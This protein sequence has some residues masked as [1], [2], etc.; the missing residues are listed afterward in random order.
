M[1]LTILLAD[2][3]AT[4][5]AAIRQFLQMVPGAEVV[6]QAQTG[7][8]ALVLAQQLR[9]DLAVLDIGMPDMSGLE[10]ARQ[11][12][13]WPL[14]PHIIFMSIHDGAAYRATARELGAIAYVGKTDFVADLLP[15]L[16]HLIAQQQSAGLAHPPV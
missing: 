13:N 14:A 4:F 3:N 2:D 15:M 1:S 9:P 8:E 10:V 16:E 11:M 12:Q 5:A 7:R 6:G